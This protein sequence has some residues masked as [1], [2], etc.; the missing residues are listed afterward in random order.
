MLAKKINTLMKI[1]E[2]SNS[3]PLMYDWPKG[4]NWHSGTVFKKASSGAVSIDSL[5]GKEHIS[6][7]DDD[8][9]AEY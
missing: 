9:T 2:Y 6:H 4:K 8:S 7:D 1:K 5:V 3:F